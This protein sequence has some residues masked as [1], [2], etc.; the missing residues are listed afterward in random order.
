VSNIFVSTDPRADTHARVARF[1]AAT[2]LIGRTVYLTGARRSLE[3]IWRVY[4]VSAA[5]DGTT[6]LLIDRTG[7]ERVAFGVEQITPEGLSHDI[8][9]L[10]VA[11]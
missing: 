3:H 11:R 9:L 10:L 8:R 2:S 1:L 7:S 5:E 6:V 4:H